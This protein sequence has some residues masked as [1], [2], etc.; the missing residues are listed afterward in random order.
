MLKVARVLELFSETVG[1]R[2]SARLEPPHAAC[3]HSRTQ[4]DPAVASLRQANRSQGVALG[5]CHRQ[6]SR[7]TEARACFRRRGV[8]DVAIRSATIVTWCAR[9]T[10]EAG[11]TRGVPVAHLALAELIGNGAKSEVET[12][13]AHLGFSA[14]LRDQVAFECGTRL[15]RR[16]V[17]LSPSTELGVHGRATPG[18]VL[19][20]PGIPFLPVA[21]DTRHFGDL[22]QD[23]VRRRLSRDDDER[24][25]EVTLV[26]G[27]WLHGAVASQPRSS[28]AS[29]PQSTAG[30]HASSR[31]AMPDHADHAYPSTKR[32]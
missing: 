18:V 21:E 19:E 9:H 30:C 22:F 17:L 7:R 13:T 5:G 32:A 20:G 12:E 1:G 15:R 10:A 16:F 11:R 6:R 27:E 26:L 28:C 31:P 23:G 4:S 2:R 29:A 8:L 3:H 14:V 24:R 25:L